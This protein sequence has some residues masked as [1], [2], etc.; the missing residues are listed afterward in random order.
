MTEFK[1]KMFADAMVQAV[2]DDAIVYGGGDVQH[3]DDM[4]V[5]VVKVL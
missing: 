1:P 3:D 5:V 2:I 4:I